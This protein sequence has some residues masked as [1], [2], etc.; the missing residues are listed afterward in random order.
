MKARNLVLGLL[1]TTN[2]L[3]AQGDVFT[4]AAT[5]ATI[6][7]ANTVM[8]TSA[9]NARSSEETIA[10]AVSS[11]I[12]NSQNTVIVECP[13]KTEHVKKDG[14]WFGSYVPSLKETIKDE[15]CQWNKKAMEEL[16]GV[17]Y[18]FGKVKSIFNVRD[19]VH[20]TIELVE[21]DE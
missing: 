5:T 20:V 18:K 19:A 2:V 3:T 14:E 21:V 9:N 8:L 4:A 15:R 16:N 12:L 13:L 7:T 17:H 11:T 1:L 10:N 6:T